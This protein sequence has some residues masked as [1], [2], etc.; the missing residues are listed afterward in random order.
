MRIKA[1]AGVFAAS[2]T[3]GGAAEAAEIAWD[4]WGVPHIAGE[5]A[6]DTTYALGWAQARGRPDQLLE[7]LG[8]GRGRAAEYWGEPYYEGDALMWRMGIPQSLDAIYDV[9]GADYQAR[10]EAFAAG[11]NAWFE[12]HPESG[13]EERRRIL[14]VTARD[15]L[16]HTQRSINLYFMAGGELQAM[17]R[18]LAAA[19]EA[20]PQETPEPDAEE[21][22]SNGWAIAPSRS[23]SGHALLLQNPHLPWTGFFTWFEAHLQSPGLNAYGVGLLGQ[24]FTSI[25]FNE[26]L[27]WTHTVNRHD[28]ADVFAV[29]PEGNGYRFGEEVRPFEVEQ[30][31]L[32]VR[33]EDGAMEARDLTITRT[34]HGPILG[35]ADG[36]LYAFRV[37]GLADPAH[38]RTFA[39]IDAMSRAEN[40][41]Q[42]E[43]A[44]SQLQLTMFN[45]IYADGNG[46]ILYVSNGLYPVRSTGDEDYWE[47]PVDG[48]DPALLW[49]EYTPYE[50]LLRVANPES[51]FVQNSN[52]TGF[53]ATIPVALDPA[54]YPADWIQPDMRTRP[55]HGLEMLLG[56]ESISF[57][58]L[59]AYAH[60]TELTMADNVL[61]D[62]VSAARTVGS[63]EAVRA[64]D[65]LEAWDRR[66]DADSRGALLFT[67]W[68]FEFARGEP[69]S[70]YENPWNF[71]A[72]TNWSSGIADDVGAVEALVAVVQRMDEAGV[73]LDTPWGEAARIPDGEGGTLPSALGL[74][75]FGAFRVG[76]FEPDESGVAFT[77]DGGTTWV[78]AIEFGET[79]RARA[80]LP[81]GNFADRPEGVENQLPLLSRGELRDVN[82]TAEA[83]EA[84]TV[85]SETVEAE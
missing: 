64:A 66:S 37:A 30:V 45:A 67:L 70:L 31:S 12:A 48:S 50:G 78:A 23:E 85:M 49:T 46:E 5:D 29:T 38:A 59:I 24:P 72:P 54:D 52:E 18:Q 73:A 57:D 58:E 35:Q 83:I 7:L 68:G 22:G 47:A 14:P 44:F 60:D 81:Y 79:P 13:S 20:T 1:F 53:T 15:I 21:R 41:E 71:L 51:G 19:R 69:I 6:D 76:S 32:N 82:Y 40:R 3:M 36:R 11:I 28:P 9:Q 16:G 84:A 63:E 10:L 56:D 17:Q 62:L 34:V 26:H 42:W 74:G 77:F 65:V 61:P 75:R 27:G 8:Q 43:A 2:L 25:M 4:N 33:G 80:I 55:Q 39:Q